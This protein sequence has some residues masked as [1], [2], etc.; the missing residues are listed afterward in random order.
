M[1][2]LHINGQ[3]FTNIAQLYIMSMRCAPLPKQATFQQHAGSNFQTRC[4]WFVRSVQSGRLVR[5]WLA[6]SLADWLADKVGWLTSEDVV[7]WWMWLTRWVVVRWF[8]GAGFLFFG[9]QISYF[10]FV[11]FFSRVG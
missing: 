2:L 11:L 1:T 6:G 8:F 4:L 5:V 7:G 9:D 10:I 3:N